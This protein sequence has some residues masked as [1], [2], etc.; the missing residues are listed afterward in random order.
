MQAPVLAYVD[1]AKGLSI[2]C[3]ASSQGLGAALLQ[4]GTPLVYAGRVLTDTETKYATSEKE[5]LA[6][7]FALEKW[8]QYTFGHHVTVYLDHKPLEGITKKLLGRAPKHL[9]GMLVR[10]LAFD[11]DVRYLNGKKMFLADTFSR[12]YLR[13]PT[14]D[15]DEGLETINALTYLVMSE[16]RIRKLYQHTNNDPALQQL[17]QTI[18]EGWPE[19]KSGLSPLVIPYQTTKSGEDQ[20]LALLI[21]R[22][23]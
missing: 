16:G 13:K 15:R 8:H 6:I 18:Q 9:Q 10:A 1:P 22:C 12:T 5:M 2:Q 17:K 7:V 23:R 14:T 19:V 21:I 4:G 3:D 20:Y 11:V